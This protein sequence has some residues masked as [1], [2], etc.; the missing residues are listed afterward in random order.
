[1]AAT[2]ITPPPAARY[3]PPVHAGPGRQGVSRWDAA[4]DDERAIEAA[5]VA[6]PDGLRQVWSAYGD[7]VHT[8]CSRTLDRDRALDATQ[9][10]FIAAWRR[11]ATFDPERGSLAGWLIGIARHK[12]LGVLRTEGRAPVPV[13]SAPLPEAAVDDVVDRIADRML[14]AHALDALPER[15]RRAVTLAFYE[16]RT[17]QEVAE[18]LGL[19]LG[20]AK[21]DIRRGIA[22]LRRTMAGL[23]D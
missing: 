22:R 10:V 14:V 20:T 19:P 21:S 4:P 12:V 3:G 5:F 11:R 8:F 6:G 1:M 16:G 7:L 9:E 18:V 2:L 13:E 15:T 17:H 23:D